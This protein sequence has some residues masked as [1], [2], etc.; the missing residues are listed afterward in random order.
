M[1]QGSMTGRKLGKCNPDNKATG[2]QEEDFNLPRGFGRGLGRKISRGLGL[3]RG[4][5]GNGKGFGRGNM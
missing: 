5:G 1:G 3:G 4:R 2:N